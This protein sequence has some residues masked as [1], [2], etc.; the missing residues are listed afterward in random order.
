MNTLKEKLAA[1]KAE[2]DKKPSCCHAGPTHGG[3]SHVEFWPDPHT[4]TGFPW[5]QL[6]HH[7]LEP[8]SDDQAA[9]EKLTLAFHTADVVIIGARLT[10]LVELVLKND[11]A[12][13]NTLDS[14]YCAALGDDAWVAKITVRFFGKPQA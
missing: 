4:R 9:P 6:C 13:V 3:V 10:S 2:F 14:R 7:T 8:N 11:L 12:S 1:R 5:G